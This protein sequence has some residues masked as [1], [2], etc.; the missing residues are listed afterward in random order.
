MF[1]ID[2]FFHFLNK[3]LKEENENLKNKLQEAHLYLTK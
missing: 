3:D 2:N 1:E